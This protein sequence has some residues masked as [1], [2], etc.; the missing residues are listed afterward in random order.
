MDLVTNRQGAIYSECVESSGPD[1]KPGSEFMFLCVR[2]R[3][4]PVVSELC[5]AEGQGAS[6]SEH[7]STC[8]RSSSLV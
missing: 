5:T 1:W 2:S 6:A 7:V 8:E 3:T 4:V